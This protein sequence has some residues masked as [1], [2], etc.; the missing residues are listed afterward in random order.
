M[1]KIVKIVSIV[2]AIAL[3]L[4]CLGVFVACNKDVTYTI[5]DIF[6]GDKSA[7]ELTSY[8]MEFTLPAGWKVYTSSL[9]STDSKNAAANLNSDIGYIKSINAFVVTDGNGNLSIVKCDDDRVYFEGG[10]KGMILPS[11]IGI[12]ALRIKDGLI[13]CKFANGEAGAFDTNGRTVLS[14][15]K[16]G[17]GS[18]AIPANVKI[19]TAIK[20][21]S[22]G[23][24]AVNH[25]YDNNGQQGYTSI[26]RTNY[27]ADG[28][29]ELVCRVANADNKLDYVLGFDNQFVTVTGNSVGDVIYNI[30]QNAKG[31]VQNLNGTP[32]GT[33][34]GDGQ[35]DYFSE[36][37]YI[38]NGKFFIHEDWTVDK[39][40]EE[41]AYYDGVDYYVFERRIYEPASD[42]STAYTENADKVFLNLGNNYYSNRA[43]VDTT[44]Y[45]NDGFTYASYGLTIIDKVGFYDQFILDGNLNVV[46]SLTGNY[47]VEI[48]DQTKEEVGYYDLIMQSIDGYFYIPYLPSQVRL[49]DS[50]GN[51]V[52]Q[53]K[54]HSVIRQELSN[55]IV[56][57]AVK[58][59]DNED[60]TLYGAYNLKGEDVIKF[61]Y[62]SLSSFRGAY[63]IGERMIAYCSNCSSKVGVADS[64]CPN[65]N[66][67]VNDQK[68]VKTLEI[69]GSDGVVI[70]EM[71]DGSKPLQD[72]AT[73]SSGSS[74]YKIGCY[75]YRVDSGEKDSNGNTIYYYGVKNFNPNV[76]KNVVMPATMRAGCVLYAPESSPRD[77]FVFEK[78]T[79]SGVDTYTVYRLI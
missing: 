32:N 43:G 20:V 44:T 70:S 64:K 35:D 10:M 49:Y 17:A 75:M 8:K 55:N 72:V 76:D 7:S 58:D 68:T 50:N 11:Y 39:D 53:N 15:F 30:P 22:S 6:K 67:V 38:G 73:T 2:M 5:T 45:L 13:I 33:V 52:G 4:G 12:S 63:T 42:K 56:V 69:I 65:C 51:L 19:D 23:M 79:E 1:K 14:R 78:V 57:A 77:V 41:Y 48:K 74:I 59:P 40:N 31:G 24:I 26:Y 37:T 54:G 3:I 60:K 34:V 16:I 62:T 46:M 28:A 25:L 9:T 47:G 18:K 61:E 21:L 36:I 66:T 29:G 71:S 27:D